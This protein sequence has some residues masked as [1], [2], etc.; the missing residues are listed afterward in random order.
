[1]Q[2]RFFWLDCSGNLSPVFIHIACVRND[3]I[4]FQSSLV[5][6][7]SVGS[8]RLDDANINLQKLGSSESLSFQSPGRHW[9]SS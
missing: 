6:D 2:G 4:L 8:Q 1:M 3:I 7:G 9:Q 5:V